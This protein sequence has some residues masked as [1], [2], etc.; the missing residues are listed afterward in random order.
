M[1]P[2]EL[3]PVLSLVHIRSAFTLSA[4]AVTVNQ[5]CPQRSLH[6][7]RSYRSE[8][9]DAGLWEVKTEWQRPFRMTAST[10]L[11]LHWQSVSKRHTQN[12]SAINDAAHRS[13]VLICMKQGD[14]KWQPWPCMKAAFCS[15]CGD[16]KE[17]IRLFCCS[18]AP[19]C[20]MTHNGSN[21]TD[22]NRGRVQVGLTC[23]CTA[24]DAPRLSGTSQIS[25]FSLVH[26]RVD[27][28]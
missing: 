11:G 3:S 22:V 8:G 7:S 1:G 27:M 16:L 2:T 5:T 26:R 19:P 28:V 12:V 4:Q 9:P 18:D 15:Y 21:G 20:R 17:R 23:T 25:R 6:D 14:I 24:N 10:S 13:A